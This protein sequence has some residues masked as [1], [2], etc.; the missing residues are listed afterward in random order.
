MSLG[1]NRDYKTSDRRARKNLARHFTLMQGYIA[2]GMTREDASRK[3]LEQMTAFKK[4]SKHN[5]NE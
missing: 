4:G 1:N 2:Q 3:A 5:G